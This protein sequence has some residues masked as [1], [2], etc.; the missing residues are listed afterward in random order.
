MFIRAGAGRKHQGR[1]NSLLAGYIAGAVVVALIG[2]LAWFHVI[3]GADTFLINGRAR[4]T[5]KDANVFGPF[6]ILPA[7]IVMM[8]VL[9][10]HY[11]SLLL[12]AAIAAL[13]CLAL[14]VVVF[15]RRMGA[16]RRHR[17]SS[18]SRCAS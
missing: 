9:T 18:W 4:S 2:M 3:P 17:S 7:M 16:F 11:R 8:R 5:F 14:A 10:G 15:A 13:L 1:L 12:N 6:L